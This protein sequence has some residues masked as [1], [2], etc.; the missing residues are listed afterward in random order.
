[1][2]FWR[3]AAILRVCCLCVLAAREREIV[4]GGAVVLGR[5]V[6]GC[7]PCES[8]CAGDHTSIGAS[9]GRPIKFRNVAQFGLEHSAGGRRI[10][11]SNPA[12][13]TNFCKIRELV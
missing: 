6:L 3:A 12:V 13:P 4:G 2:D 7:R 11:G 8:R 9:L 1:M 5:R 10:A